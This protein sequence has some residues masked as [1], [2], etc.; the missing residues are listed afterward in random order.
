[1]NHYSVDVSSR[2]FRPDRNSS[3]VVSY[4]QL[5]LRV[6]TATQLITG[7]HARRCRDG[8]GCPCEKECHYQGLETAHRLRMQQFLV[9][10]RRTDSERVIPIRRLASI[11]RRHEGLSP[12]KSRNQHGE[13]AAPSTGTVTSPFQV[14]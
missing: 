4:K 14:Y 6:A 5:G 1:M 7:L 10:Q 13:V 12:M 3:C 9:S 8:L 11:L 2:N